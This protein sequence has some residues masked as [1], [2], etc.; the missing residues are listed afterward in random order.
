M[1]T[2]FK[3]S[4]YNNKVQFMC[5]MSGLMRV[6]EIVQLR[7]RDLVLTH[8][9]IIVKIPPQI[10]KGQKARTTFFSKEASKLLRPRLRPLE[11]KELVRKNIMIKITLSQSSFAI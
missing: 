4:T 5:Q 7:K 2:I 11:D 3:S 6:G 9:N 1:Q 8:E 10:T